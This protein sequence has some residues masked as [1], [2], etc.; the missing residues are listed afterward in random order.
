[1]GD[2]LGDHILDGLEKGGHLVDGKM[3]LDVLK[4]PHHGSERNITPTFFKNIT[5]DVYLASA[6]GR[7]GTR[8]SRSSNGS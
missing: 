3:H 8:I 6:N 5:A 7:T 1:M 2:A 4:L